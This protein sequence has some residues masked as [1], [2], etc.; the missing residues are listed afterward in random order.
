V[1]T[2]GQIL[3]KSPEGPSVAPSQGSG[4]SEPGPAV[5]SS[6][7]GRADIERIALLSALLFLSALLLVVGRTAR[8]AL[9]LTHF[10]VSW[11]APMWM[12]IGLVSSLS[13]LVYER[14]LRKLPRARFGVVF[15]LVGAGSYLGLRVL[16]GHE[17]H[18]AVAVFAIWSEVIANLTGVLAWSIAQDLYDAR[19]AKRDFGLIGL[20]RV[21]GTVVSGLGAGAIVPY[22][23]T[24]NLIFVLIA[25]LCGVAVLC[26][27]IA[28]RCKLPAPDRSGERVLQERLERAPLLRSR[29][30]LSIAAT[31]LLLFTVLTIGD[32]QFKA[33][34][35]SAYPDRDA[36]A[37]FM[38]T[39]YGA[40]G[41]AG[42]FVQLVVTPRLLARWGV[43]GGAAA[44]PV[45]FLCATVALLAFPS[46]PL[47]A[48]LKA[49]DHALQFSVFDATLQF[50]YFPFPA[51][52][53][54]RVRT[55]VGAVMKPLGYGLGALILML[56]APSASAAPPGAALIAQAARLGWLTLPLGLCVLPLLFMVRRG[57]VAA[58]QGTLRRGRTE[59][60]APASEAHATKVLRDAL[61]RTDAPQVLFAMDRLRVI[62]PTFV[63]A[64]LPSL[65]RH[66]APRVRA[67]ALR[68]CWEL[69]HDD[70]VA[71][72]RTGLGDADPDVRVEAVEAL[73]RA[74][75]DDAH[76][77]LVALSE[78]KQDGAVRA[79][80]IAALLRHGGLDGMLDGAPRLRALLDSEEPADRAAAACALGRLGQPSL[81]R[82]VARLLADE[83]PKVRRAALA[84]A[85]T[86]AD[87]R[88][89]P[90]LLDALGAPD[91][92][93]DAAHALIALGDAAVPALAAT[94]ADPEASIDVRRV[95]PRV[96]YRIGTT[97]ALGALLERLDESDERLRQKVLA[98][99]SRL[100]LALH[101]PAL[102]LDAIRTR[103][104]REAH[105]HET[106]REAYLSAR[107]RVARP[108]LDQ[109]VLSRLRKGLIR[110]LRLC[111]L[112]YPREAVAAARAHVFG[113]DPVLR[114][115]AFEVL[116]SLLDRP[117][118][119]RLLEL[120]ERYVAL[121]ERFP[122]SRAAP[123]P[124]ALSSFLRIEIGADDP[125]RAALALDAVACHRLSEGA[126]E[127]MRALAHADPLVREAAAIAVA[128]T[129]PAGA[130]EA[131]R[132]L[133]RDPDPVVA[134]W[135]A[136]WARTGR[137]GIDDHEG[138]SDAMYTTIEKVLFLQRVPVF[139]QVSGEELMTLARTSEV[140]NM[141]RDA[142]VFRQGEP[143]GALYFL[144]SGAVSLRVDDKEVA[145]LGP[146]DVFGEMSIFDREPRA[147]TAVVVEPSEL[148]VVQADDFYAAV[149]DTVEF[150]VA[151][152][153]VLN[154]RLREADRRLSEARKELSTAR[155]AESAAGTEAK[156]PA[157]G[158]RHG[159]EGEED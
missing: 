155:G 40:V 126:A 121:S 70:T 91:L 99:A 131:L 57:Y 53:R 31:I 13:A 83:D 6:A 46:V 146:N 127:A 112:V 88:L 28:H 15:C 92:S 117:L 138:D 4:S 47:A 107:P 39:F 3:P 85:A 113:R 74:L 67:S 120:F 87:P 72:A 94:L 8:D 148:L 80:A 119:V 135:A 68:L 134:R 128:E 114:A 26:R 86:A 41:L 104:E 66:E 45:A 48:T 35:R 154:R 129:R 64:A 75:R 136:Y 5:A 44:M 133:V 62:D 37:R 59:P 11:V 52:Q 56:V 73:A 141:P 159:W 14:A 109:H 30:V 108:L 12:G 125:Y 111:E 19:R 43:L 84:A 144:I 122:A 157:D 89:L 10:P 1:T 149:H 29:Y 65:C 152:I 34:A 27:V 100:R 97:T 16:I 116:E 158:G 36:L 140:V 58:M 25:A 61:G 143:G 147:A 90:P 63:R 130:E 22:L 23:G 103:I 156:A 101:A 118:R 20:G 115:N 77:E 145:R 32:Y 105:V 38:G 150:A 60:T 24:E 82:A 18:A 95:I 123:S 102:P 142:V 2:S 54:D 7:Q 21:A 137:S 106:D 78:R 124:G 49:S 151:V 153:K 9:V 79:A 69:G 110:I 51:A 98:S 55:L 93:A 81:V 76:D 139:A 96:L 132:A 42:L 33:I 71:L 50:L 17:V